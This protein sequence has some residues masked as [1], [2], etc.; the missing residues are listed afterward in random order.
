[1][2]VFRSEEF[3]AEF[4]D[5][6]R[7]HS[8]RKSLLRKISNIEGHLNERGYNNAIES[9]VV[10]TLENTYIHKAILGKHGLNVRVTCFFPKKWRETI[11][12]FLW[13]FIEGDSRN[14]YDSAIARSERIAEKWCRDNCCLLPWEV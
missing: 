4:G 1:M 5:F 7:K 9:R 12:V 13:V 8:A 11:C 3:K 10:F 14:D 2:E 6:L